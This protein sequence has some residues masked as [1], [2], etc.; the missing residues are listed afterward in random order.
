MSRTNWKERHAKA[1][2]TV[3][4]TPRMPSHVAI[5]NRTA[6]EDY[7]RSQMEAGIVA[8]IKG[9][10]LLALGYRNSIGGNLGDDGYFDE[11]ATDLLKALRAALN[12]DLGD[13]LD[14]GS[15]DSEVLRLAKEHGVPGFEADR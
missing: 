8:L 7:G 6:M 13:R 12:F 5:G 15:L 9:F 1:L 4:I 2:T 11:H 10:D 3:A 14:C